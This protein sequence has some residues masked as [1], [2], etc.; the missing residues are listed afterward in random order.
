MGKYNRF[1][2]ALHRIFISHGWLEWSHC[3]N[4]SVM[5]YVLVRSQVRKCGRVISLD[6]TKF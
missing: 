5:E 2:I 1:L 3:H 6:E 4:Q